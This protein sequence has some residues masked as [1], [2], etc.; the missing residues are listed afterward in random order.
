MFYQQYAYMTIGLESTIV[1]RDIEFRIC[2]GL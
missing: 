2:V 1:G